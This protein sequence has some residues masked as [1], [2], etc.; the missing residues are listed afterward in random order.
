MAETLGSLCDKLTIVKLKQWHSTGAERLESLALQEK[1]LAGEI[2][3]FVARASCGEIPLERLTFAANKVYNERTN[4]VAAVDGTIGHLFAKLA[5]VNCQLWHEVDKGYELANVPADEKD[6][7]V[8]QLAILNLQ[9][10]QC[11]DQI[12][13]TFRQLISSASARADEKAVG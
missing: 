4:I 10:N 1:Q 13:R 8:R 5:E 7:L 11:I 6:G 3:E 2:D 9:R 12:D